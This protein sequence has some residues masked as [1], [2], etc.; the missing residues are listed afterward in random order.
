MPTC[1]LA[2]SPQAFAIPVTTGDVCNLA[3]YMQSL[4]RLGT[5]TKEL[6]RQA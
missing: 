1:E 4:Q 2:K 6:T 5:I 3:A